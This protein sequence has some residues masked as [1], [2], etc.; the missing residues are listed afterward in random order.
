MSKMSIL[1]NITITL[2]TLTNESHIKERRYTKKR[3]T[4]HKTP[5]R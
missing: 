2:K 4:P 3:Y 1:Q 5:N